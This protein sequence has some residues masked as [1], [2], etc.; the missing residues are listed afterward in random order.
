MGCD[1]LL[2]LDQDSKHCSRNRRKF[3]NLYQIIA[4]RVTFH[5]PP[6]NDLPTYIFEIYQ[7]AKFLV[8]K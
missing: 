8:T 1:Q 7:N 6:T 5:E 4:L 2:Q 3:S